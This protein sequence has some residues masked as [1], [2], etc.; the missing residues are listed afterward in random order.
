MGRPVKFIKIEDETVTVQLPRGRKILRSNVVKAV[1]NPI[2]GKLS[3][4]EKVQEDDTCDPL[5]IGNDDASVMFANEDG[6]AYSP[7][8]MK[9]NEKHTF[10][11]SRKKELGRTN[12]QRTFKVVS[13]SSVPKGTRIFGTRSFDALKTVQDSWLEILR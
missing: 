1:T 3:G 7:L 5:I 10:Q 11:E 12:G 6:C 4:K 2:F 9:P 13:K 8:M